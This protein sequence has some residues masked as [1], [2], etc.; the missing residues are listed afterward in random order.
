[1]TKPQ[2]TRKSEPPTAI[3][4]GQVW[5]ITDD[6]NR[7]STGAEIWP[8]RYGV[9]ISANPIAAES[10]AVSVA[11]ITTSPT[12]VLGAPQSPTHVKCRISGKD[13]VV[14]C[15]QPTTVDKSR[16]LRYSHTLRSSTMKKI[17]TALCCA[18]NLS[19]KDCTASFAKWE[20]HIQSGTS[21]IGD[22]KTVLASFTDAV[23]LTRENTLLRA[24]RDSYR[25]LLKI[26]EEVATDKDIDI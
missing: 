12:K 5:F 4:R 9:I 2:Q 20:K 8:N 13:A 14:L 18:L 17:D 19:L 23:R 22:D 3:T 15:E 7:P 21:S 16:L 26:R 11:Y 25:T 10:G 6:P 1:M 24:E